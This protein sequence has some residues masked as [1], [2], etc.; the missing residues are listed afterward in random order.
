[1]QLQSDTSR[2]SIEGG[3]DEE[4]ADTSSQVGNAP[5]DEQDRSP[6]QALTFDAGDADD[7]PE[8]GRRSVERALGAS[9]SDQDESNNKE[10]P[11]KE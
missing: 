4:G 1:M 11:F 5:E 2:A 9:D 8:S 6:V 7:L 3:G 10:S